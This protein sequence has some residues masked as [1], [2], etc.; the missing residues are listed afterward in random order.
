MKYLT[1]ALTFCLLSFSAKAIGIENLI[2]DDIDN[3]GIGL[4]LSSFYTG[5]WSEKPIIDNQSAMDGVLTLDILYS[6]DVI[7]QSSICIGQDCANGMTFGFDTQVFRENNLRIYFDDTSNSASFPGND[8][9]ILINDSN[10]GGDNYFA[11][12]DATSGRVP[13]LIEAGAEDHSL[14]VDENCHVGIGTNTPSKAIHASKGD[15]PAIRFEQDGSEGFTPQIWDVGGNEANFFIKDVTNSS[16]IPFKI[17]PGA[18]ANSLCIDASGNITSVGTIT[19]S[20]LRLKKNILSLGSMMPIIEMLQ[21]KKY[22]FKSEYGY[23][24]DLQFGLLAQDLEEI[25]PNLVSEIGQLTSTGE[26]MKG[27]NYTSLI[28]VLIKGIQEQQEVILT[29]EDRIVELEKG[30]EELKELK[31]QIALLSQKLDK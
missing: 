14:Y 10:N 18:P 2:F 25:L 8:W 22:Y 15:T 26:P 6:D 11:I 23:T 20:D 9:R 7:V 12:E 5:D 28:P 4:P 29:Q 3:N 19:G 24:H 16:T 30:I 17:A 1:L 27:I 31:K 13:F 21:P